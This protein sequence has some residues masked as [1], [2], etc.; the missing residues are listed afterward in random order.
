MKKFK[1]SLALAILVAFGLSFCGVFSEGAMAII[2]TNLTY[3]GYHYEGSNV[4]KSHNG[5]AIIVADFANVTC[6]GTN[7]VVRTIAPGNAENTKK[8]TDL[9]CG[10]QITPTEYVNGHQQAGKPYYKNVHDI[11]SQLK[12]NGVGIYDCVGYTNKK[13]VDASDGCVVSIWKGDQHANVVGQQGGK[14]KVECNHIPAGNASDVT[15]ISTELGGGKTFKTS[16]TAGTCD[17]TVETALKEAGFDVGNWNSGWYKKDDDTTTK[18][19]ETKKD[20]DTQKKDTPTGGGGTKTDTDD[21]PAATDDDDDP[22]TP[23][24]WG[25]M[26]YNNEGHIDYKNNASILKGCSGAD[27]G[28]GEGIKCIIELVI[29][30]MTIGVGILSVVGITVVGVQYLSAGGNEERTRKAKHRL[31]EIVIG[32]VLYVVAYAALKWLLPS[33]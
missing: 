4:E 22:V 19:D 16:I 23:S 9:K 31:F 32:V 7:V 27:N 6:D 5:S 28:E 33:L 8:L 20:D 1:K 25:N 13:G 15:Y 29:D 11:E 10:E 14:A 26:T 17:G 18:K 2:S 24:T 30:I 12:S 21:D 3:K